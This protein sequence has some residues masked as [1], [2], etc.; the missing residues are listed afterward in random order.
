MIVDEV[1]P[2][3]D[4]VVP[5]PLLLRGIIFPAALLDTA[6]PVPEGVTGTPR[7]SALPR[8]GRVRDSAQRTLKEEVVGGGETHSEESD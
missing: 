2:F 3:N 6:D 8:G 1:E 4:G 5:A 7:I